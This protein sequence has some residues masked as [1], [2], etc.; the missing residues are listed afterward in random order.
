MVKKKDTSVKKYS[1]V[2]EEVLANEEEINEEVESEKGSKKVEVDEEPRWYHYLIVS[3]IFIGVFVGL[4]FILDYF[5]NEHAKNSGK[6]ILYD[7]DFEINGN[8]ASIQF[9]NPVEDIEEMNFNIGISKYD[10]LDSSEI[11]LSFAEYGG[12]E[13]GDLAKTSTR[14]L[15][16]LIK[17]YRMDL[18][19]KKHVVLEKDFSCLNSTPNVKVIE[20][21]PYSDTNEVTYD[22]E[23]GCIRFLTDD[24]K[25]M[26][27]LGDKFFYTLINE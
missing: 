6:V 14:L 11:Y 19:P 21:N 18:D 1:K 27:A 22:E 2:K 16:F 10:L 20:F 4:F 5:E 8:D 7:Y 25:K 12:T 24:S 3:I 23:T 15:S 13:N 9:Y 26:A 17:I